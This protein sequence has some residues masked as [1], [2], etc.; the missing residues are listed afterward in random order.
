MMLSIVAFC[1]LLNNNAK[2]CVDFFSF[3]FF[4]FPVIF[5]CHA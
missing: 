4:L 1:N 3:L 5:S 2:S